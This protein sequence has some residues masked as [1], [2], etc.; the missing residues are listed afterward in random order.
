MADGE[1][2]LLKVSLGIHHE[3]MMIQ[4]DTHGK[5]RELLEHLVLRVVRWT[6]AVCMG[7]WREPRAGWLLLLLL[8]LL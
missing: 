3:K 5:S 4:T 8:L 6:G 1:D 7:E 2:L